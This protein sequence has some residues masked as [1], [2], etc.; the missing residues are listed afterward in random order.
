MSMWGSRRRLL[1]GGLG[2]VVAA[3]VLL[4]PGAREAGAVA[5]AG[6]AAEVAVAVDLARSCDGPVE[7]LS[8]RTP[9]ETLTALP[10]G[11]LTWTASVVAERALVDGVWRSVDPTL[12]RTSGGV[13]PVASVLP[14]RFSPGGAK[15][16][17]ARIEHRGRVLEV[18]SPFGSLP[19]PVVSG[20]AVTYPSVL[21]DV[22]LMVT[23]DSDGTGFSQV[24]VVRT[25]A[26]AADARLARISFPTRTVGLTVAE[27]GGGLSAVDGSGAQV[28]KSPAPVMWDSSGAPGTTRTSALAGRRCDVI[29]GECAGSSCTGLVITVNSAAGS[30]PTSPHTTRWRCTSVPGSAEPNPIRLSAGRNRLAPTLCL[31][32]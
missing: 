7:V 28:F 23:V 5:C 20:P 14:M 9:W 27:A 31:F 19:A 12:V 13:E 8:G 26:A 32:V 18:V 17:L 16:P 2:G 11:E 29:Y 22:D 25:P 30:R 21:P 24:L 3:G 4:W 10:S 15:A 1:A 6:A